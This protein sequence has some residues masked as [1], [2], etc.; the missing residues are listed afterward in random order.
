MQTTKKL[1]YLNL[2]FTD[3]KDKTAEKKGHEISATFYN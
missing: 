3:M 2:L 1:V